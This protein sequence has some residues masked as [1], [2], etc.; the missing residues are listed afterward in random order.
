MGAATEET[1]GTSEEPTRR[2]GELFILMRQQHLLY[3]PARLPD[4]DYLSVL[5]SADTVDLELHIN[6]YLDEGV[7]AA[8]P[9][10]F[11]LVGNRLRM[12]D[13]RFWLPDRW[14]YGYQGQPPIVD[15]LTDF[16]RIADSLQEFRL[17]GVETL[18]NDDSFSALM[19]SLSTA[20]NLRRLSLGKV[21]GKRVKNYLPL[22]SLTQLEWL[23]L[24]M[25]PQLKDS[26]LMDITGRLVNLKRLWLMD[27]PYITIM[28]VL[29][30]VN[31]LEALEISRCKS[32]IAKKFFQQYLENRHQ[33][34]KARQMLAP[35]AAANLVDNLEFVKIRSCSPID[36]KYLKWGTRFFE[37][38]GIRVD[39]DSY[40]HDA[41]LI[42][43][44][45]EKW[46]DVSSIRL[47]WYNCQFCGSKTVFQ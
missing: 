25:C 16:S 4:L 6:N 15:F 42:V 33:L 26:Q 35:E 45:W 7:A 8:I 2:L 17:Y 20:P 47:S 37:R 9:E 22:G 18:L 30:L 29:A 23:Y 10:A 28:P 14:N 13:L 40:H 12:F 39:I 3:G 46:R 41:I 32:F 43:K 21:C 24:S 36:L 11:R 34:E 5:Q 38:F 27:V 44:N 31:R 1:G 19:A